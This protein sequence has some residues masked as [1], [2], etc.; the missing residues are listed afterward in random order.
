MVQKQQ[1]W[2]ILE[3]CPPQ[4]I[5]SSLYSLAGSCCRKTWVS[6]ISKI[7]IDWKHNCTPLGSP[8]GSAQLA[9][10]SLTFR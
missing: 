5:E 2:I 3:Y 6:Y 8:P 10:S 1:L 4:I 7:L 9:P